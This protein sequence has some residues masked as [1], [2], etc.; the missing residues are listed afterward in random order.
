MEYPHSECK[1]VV[2]LQTAE[3]FAL[4]KPMVG[5]KIVMTWGVCNYF[6]EIRM[7]E[8]PYHKNKLVMRL[9]CTVCGTTSYTTATRLGQYDYILGGGWFVV[10]VFS[11][12]RK[13]GVFR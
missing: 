4:T 5:T 1:T 10:H 2:G 3:Q 7:G 8:K 6:G 11:S 12:K 9:L 13:I